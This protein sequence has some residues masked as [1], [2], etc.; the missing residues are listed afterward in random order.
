[1]FKSAFEAGKKGDSSSFD[2]W[3]SKFDLSQ[4]KLDSIFKPMRPQEVER[5]FINRSKELKKIAEIIGYHKKNKKL[6]FIHIIGSNGIG[7][8]AFLQTIFEYLNKIDP[9]GVL[10]TSA[11]F[12]SKRNEEED[13]E[14]FFDEFLEN[15][16]SKEVCII[17]DCYRDL[18]MMRNYNLRQIKKDLT[19]TKPLIIMG[20]NGMGWLTFKPVL[21]QEGFN[22]DDRNY[23]ILEPF[24]NGDIEQILIS[25]L[26]YLK[27]S[28]N[29]R[30]FSDNSIKKISKSCRGLPLLAFHLLYLSLQECF[31]NKKNKVDD[32]LIDELLK[33]LKLL[34]LEEG[35][36]ELNTTSRLVLIE[37]LRYPSRGITSEQLSSKLHKDRTSIL[38]HISK[39][40]ENG[41]IETN[42]IGKYVYFF[43]NKFKRPIID[44]YFLRTGRDHYA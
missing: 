23:L 5:L 12:F 4:I 19:Y 29:I 22:E 25:R 30:P 27:N 43:I 2:M 21:Y 10:I 24:N 15:A 44:L 31:Y 8:T 11:S 33:E 6:G 13:T 39:L 1:M 14:L 34:N 38:Y 26:H 3:L 7:L 20:W 37:I 18:D 42:R 28:K 16:K 41:I 9:K 35:L 36:D 40:Q 32:V 17:D